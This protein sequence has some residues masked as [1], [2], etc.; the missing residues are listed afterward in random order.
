MWTDYFAAA[1]NL[2]HQNAWAQSCM[3]CSCSEYHYSM[4]D[5]QGVKRFQILDTC[6][7]KSLLQQFDERNCY[8]LFFF[9]IWHL[10]LQ[11]GLHHFSDVQVI[12]FHIYFI[13]QVEWTLQ[14]TLWANFA[15]GMWTQTIQ[16][17]GSNIQ[18]HTVLQSYG[19]LQCLK[20]QGFFA[21]T[22]HVLSVVMLL[23]ELLWFL[24]PFGGDA[25][26][27]TYNV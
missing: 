25:T 3:L 5:L 17:C 14:M 2:G 16:L 26:L 8:F 24:V 10:G 27:S 20:L 4:I 21:L 13:M 23:K 18:P 22:I 6:P 7:A 11:C 15:S 19:V 9:D 12:L 1:A